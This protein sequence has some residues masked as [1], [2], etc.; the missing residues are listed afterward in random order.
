[1]RASTRASS[2]SLGA[3]CFS[4]RGASSPVV[5]TPSG[6]TAWWWMFRFRS[7][8]KRW[9]KTTEPVLASRRPA[10]FACRRCQRKTSCIRMLAEAVVALA[11]R[12]RATRTMRGYDNTHCRYATRG[13]TRSTRCAAAS[14]ILRA[15]H[16]GQNARPLQLNATRISSPHSRQTTRAKPSE[17]N[18]HGRYRRSSSTTYRGSAIPCSASSARKLSKCSRTTWWS[19]VLSG[20]RRWYPDGSGLAALPDLHSHVCPGLLAVHPQ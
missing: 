8:P 9:L 18:P 15:Q 10:R 16:D 3:A 5:N 4:N 2:S 6:T 19:T 12:A 20:S 14:L 17:S 11:S 7:D 1:M 13:R